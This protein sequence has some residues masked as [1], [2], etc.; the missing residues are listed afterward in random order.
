MKKH[1]SFA[2]VLMLLSVLL[3]S[4][5][6][7]AM[8]VA[9]DSNF[10]KLAKDL[11]VTDANNGEL[12]M[13]IYPKANKITVAEF[14]SATDKSLKVVKSTNDDP[15][16]QTVFSSPVTDVI[17]LDAKIY[18]ENTTSRVFFMFREPT[19]TF[20]EL[21][22]FYPDGSITTAPKALGEGETGKKIGEWKAKEWIKV[23]AK[24]NPSTKKYSVWLN[25]VLVVDNAAIEY[26]NYAS[27]GHARFA[28]AGGEGEATV[29]V[30]DWRVYTGSEDIM[31]DTHFGGT[32]F[33][34]TTKAAVTT[35][36]AATGGTTAPKTG[37]ATVFVA[38]MLVVAVAS[39]ATIKRASVKK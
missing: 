8:T 21:V 15:Y 39:F 38:I 14:P 20:F 22:S 31:P 34:T 33:V 7:A 37:D 3:M 36:K 9:T 26:D 11:V 29:Y 27:V 17:V 1:A 30:N 5:V 23:V 19:P 28:I 25:E 32:P 16:M 12:A 6:G 18:I 35:T 10:D 13:Q 4:T 24:V 2:V